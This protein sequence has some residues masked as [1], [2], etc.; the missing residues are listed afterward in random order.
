MVLTDSSDV[1]IQRLNDMQAFWNLLLGRH[2]LPDLDSPPTQIL[3]IGCGSGI[4][5]IQVADEFPD[6]QVHGI[7]ISPIQPHLVPPNCTFYVADILEG[8][9][10]QDKHFDF[11]HSR[12]I[13]SG[14]PGGN[15][16]VYLRELFRLLKPGGWVQLVEMDPWPCC[17]DGTLS[18]D[19]AWITYLIAMKEMLERRR[20]EV[21]GLGNNLRGYVEE[22]G[23]MNITEQHK[24]CPLGK[25][26]KSIPFCLIILMR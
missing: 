10:F 6:A 22:A 19:S 21:F 14:I 11:I 18:E 20:V 1:E 17:D 7:D 4:Y 2:I 16:V 25:W 26:T 9:W 15:W 3:D 24:K 13:H 23:F 5:C 12:D 8:L